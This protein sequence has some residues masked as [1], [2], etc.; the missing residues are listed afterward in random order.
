LKKLKGQNYFTKKIKKK[1]YKAAG[2][3]LPFVMKYYPTAR[4]A[5]RH[6]Q[7]PV[8]GRKYALRN[9]YFALPLRLDKYAINYK[10]KKSLIEVAKQRFMEKK[11]F[12]KKKNR[13]K[14]IYTV[15]KAANSNNEVR[16]LTKVG[17]ENV[18]G[19]RN[20]PNYFSKSSA[21]ALVRSVASTPFV[22]KKRSYCYFSA[23]NF[24]EE[25]A[26]D[27]S[28]FFIFIIGL[29][30][31]SAKPGFLTHL[32]PFRKFKRKMFSHDFL[33]DPFNYYINYLSFLISFRPFSVI[34]RDLRYIVYILFLQIYRCKFPIITHFFRP[35]K[36]FVPRYT[37]VTWKVDVITY[38]G[39]RSYLEYFRAVKYNEYLSNLM[40][41]IKI[42]F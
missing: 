24:I 31:L 41:K 11:K 29:N 10:L 36:R 37:M 27:K 19:P 20:R 23:E 21:K 9:F 8:F 15:K 32:L 26:I 35:I 6:G 4:H 22:T 30:F 2:H 3:E 1:Y 16:L 13:K 17:K 7:K 42:P 18:F 38:L 40:P 33:F 39:L 14:Y 5:L 34:F 28:S 12:L 25:K